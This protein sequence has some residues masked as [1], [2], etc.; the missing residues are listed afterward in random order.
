M[1]LQ[2]IALFLMVAIVVIRAYPPV[3]YG[4]V[5]EYKNDYEGKT[6][7]LKFNFV[8]SFIKFSD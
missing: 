1:Y 4:Y 7:H 6:N 2:T 3:E 5:K 8:N